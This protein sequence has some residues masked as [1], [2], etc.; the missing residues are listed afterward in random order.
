MTLLKGWCHVEK[1]QQIVDV[2]GACMPSDHA[3][4][5][6]E[7]SK[8]AC[9]LALRAKSNKYCKSQSVKGL[10]LLENPNAVKTITAFKAGELV[11]PWL[12]PRAAP[13]PTN[14]IAGHC[15][16]GAHNHSPRSDANT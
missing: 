13:T 7:A 1:A 6:E 5:G 12:P 4:F 15:P 9:M 3:G 10:Q 8:A 11:R 2:S 16:D 14:H